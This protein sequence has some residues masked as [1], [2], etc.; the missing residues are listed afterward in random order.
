MLGLPGHDT[1]AT[2][3][4]R[5]N[6]RKLTLRL[7]RQPHGFESGGVVEV[8]LLSDDLPL[9]DHVDACHVKAEAYA[10]GST[11]SRPVPARDDVVVNLEQFP[12]N[13]LALPIPRLLQ[14]FEP[15]P[16]DRA[17]LERSCFHPRRVR[18][19]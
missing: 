5:A 9:L 8:V 1:T 16:D 7:P 15:L 11:A 14:R 19:G 12:E 13:D 4:R 18:Y 2:R 10:A 3:G 17:P 6:R